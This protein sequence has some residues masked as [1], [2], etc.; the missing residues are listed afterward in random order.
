MEHLITSMRM[1]RCNLTVINV[2]QKVTKSD[3]CRDCELTRRR[4]NSRKSE[5]SGNRERRRKIR[6]EKQKMKGHASRFLNILARWMGLRPALRMF[7]SNKLDTHS[8]CGSYPHQLDMLRPVARCPHSMR[9]RAQAWMDYRS[10]QP[11][12]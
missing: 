9:K 7:S 12:R 6:H 3:S 5:K 11:R 8:L 4:Q 10:M 1:L 2:R